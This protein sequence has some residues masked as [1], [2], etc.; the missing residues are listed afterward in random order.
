MLQSPRLLLRRFLPTDAPAFYQLNSLP[1]VVQYTAR[2]ALTSEAQALAVLT[3][4]AFSAED[5]VGLGRFAC[6][7]KNSHQLLGLVG[8]RR[9]TEMA[10]QA[11][12]PV[13]LG[14][15]FLPAT[16]GQGVAAEAA[17]ALLDY[18][19]SQLQ[20]PAVAATVYQQNQAS[21]QVL[22][23]LGFCQQ[24]LAQ[25]QNHPSA[26]VQDFT[27]QRETSSALIYLVRQAHRE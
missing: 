9:E 11:L 25:E 18:A 4:A 27:N 5:A 24:A 19:F 16:W 13:L 6:V 3:D 1:S 7:D 17:S 22:K 20:L 12:A 10:R 15:R 8:L 26:I 23:K 14:Y 21:L 2:P